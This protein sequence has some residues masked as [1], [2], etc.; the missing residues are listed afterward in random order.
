MQNQA[1]EA[2]SLV[3]YP[4][5]F[6]GSGEEAVARSQAVVEQVFAGKPYLTHIQGTRYGRI[7]IVFIPIPDLAMFNDRQA[8]LKA[9]VQGVQLAVSLGARSVSFTGM[10]PTATH[11]GH[12]IA[13]AVAGSYDHPPKLTT[14]HAAV[15]AAFVMNL[16]KILACSRRDLSQEALTFV[17]LGSIGRGVC[18]LLFRLDRQPASLQLVELAAKLPALERLRRELVQSFGATCPIHLVGVDPGSP[19]PS[20]VYARSSLVC[21]ASSAPEI[22][23]IERLLPGTLVVDDS[24]PLG[25]CARTAIRRMEDRHDILMTVAGGLQ[26][27]ETIEDPGFF[28]TGK[29][30]IDAKLAQIVNVAHVVP[31]AMTGCVYASVLT[32]P[33][34]LPFT[35]GRV[36]SRDG[37]AFYEKLRGEGFE[38]TPLHIFA[39]HLEAGVQLASDALIE[40]LAA[41]SWGAG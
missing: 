12:A 33:L 15:I 27:P 8:T 18:E 36:R 6:H 13:D 14:G 31:R 38:G 11:Y 20:A 24:F 23:D 32:H 22:I 1:V 4:C 29:A 19:L 30:E 9:A 35:L 21:S 17:G 5:S 28:P 2:A 34:G 40:T 7:G 25:F 41:G 16:E 10:I 39:L 37:L 26:G 3:A